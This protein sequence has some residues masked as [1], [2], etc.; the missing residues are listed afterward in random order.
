MKATFAKIGTEWKI[1]TDM[2]TSD[3]EIRVTLKSGEKKMVKIVRGSEKQLPSGGYLYTLAD[4]E[5]KT[6]TERKPNGDARYDSH[7]ESGVCEACEFNQDAGDMRGC[8][9]HRGNPKC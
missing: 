5:R 1:K 9:K 2:M 6:S 4:S 8:P 7:R 3:T